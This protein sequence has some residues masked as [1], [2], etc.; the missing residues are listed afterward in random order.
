[1]DIP[2]INKDQECK[3]AAEFD[4]Y[5]HARVAFEVSVSQLREQSLPRL[6]RTTRFVRYVRVDFSGRR[7]K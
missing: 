1:M 3:M 7:T 2:D 5:M 6:A 4:L